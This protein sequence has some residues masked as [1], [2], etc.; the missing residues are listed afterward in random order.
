M[1]H[2]E[3]LR[4]N[5][6]LRVYGVN[7][8]LPNVPHGTLGPVAAVGADLLCQSVRKL[9][10]P[11]LFLCPPKCAERAHLENGLASRQKHCYFSALG[12]LWKNSWKSSLES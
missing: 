10:H 6:L 2:V 11:V 9:F 8:F 3:H 1:F 7:L 4:A 5:A 12:E